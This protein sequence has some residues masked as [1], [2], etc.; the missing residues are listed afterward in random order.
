MADNDARNP[1]PSETKTQYIA[2]LAGKKNS[3]FF[4]YLFLE[5]IDDMKASA[6]P[7]SIIIIEIT[8]F[9]LT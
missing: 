9:G 2:A 7:T 3:Y 1:N 6:L 4:Y 8:T 5:S